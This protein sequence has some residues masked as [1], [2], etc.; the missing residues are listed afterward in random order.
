MSSPYKAR[1]LV[2]LEVCLLH[3]FFGA[4]YT[5]FWLDKDASNQQREQKK[6]NETER[7]HS[8]MSFGTLTLYVRFLIQ[9]PSSFGTHS[10]FA[11]HLYKHTL[12]TQRDALFIC[13]N[14]QHP[15]TNPREKARSQFPYK[16]QPLELI[17]QAEGL[18]VMAFYRLPHAHS[19]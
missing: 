19:Q 8:P 10:P 6:V 7:R 5:W 11:A 16:E 3:F 4:A 14:I 18:C 1:T 9:K 17:Q 15:C 12:G 2:A 13:N